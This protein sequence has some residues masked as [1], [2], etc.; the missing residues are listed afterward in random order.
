MKILHRDFKGGEVKLR[1]ENPDDLWYLF[2]IVEK[3]DLVFGRTQRKVKIGSDEHVKSVKKT[4]NLEIKAEKIEWSSAANVLRINGVVVEGVENVPKGSYHTIDVEV[5]DVIKIT[6]T[7]WFYHQIQRLEEA[8]KDIALN[9][10]IVV[11]DRESAIFAMLKRYGY[12]ILSRL[13]GEVPKKRIETKKESTFFY[14]IIKQM[15]GYA[16]RYSASKIVVASPAFWKE[17]LLKLIDDKALRQRIVLSS[18]SAVEKNAVDEVLRKEE[19]RKI[20]MEERISKEIALFDE[21]MSE[22]SKNG[23]AAYG[24]DDVERNVSIGNIKNLLV[25]DK[26]IRE[27]RERDFFDRIDSLM[28]NVGKARGQ[29]SILSSEQ[30]VGKRLDG[31]GGIAAILRYRAQ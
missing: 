21:L 18:C 7:R 17:D 12:E 27:M 31:L 13:E 26:F 23:L 16:E 2:S 22:I 19:V 5:G 8:T 1:I 10:L 3:G 4:M 25:T 9:V 11:F 30:D 28:K 29:I 6:K 14:E 15:K 24:L 20:I